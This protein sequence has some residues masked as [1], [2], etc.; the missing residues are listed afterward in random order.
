MRLDAEAARNLL[1]DAW[2]RWA[3]RCAELADDDWSAP[4]RCTGWD[5]AALIAHVCPEPTMFD[6]LAEAIT[7]PPAAVTDAAILLRRFNEPD[8]VANTG[9]DALAER[10]VTAAAALTPQTAAARFTETAERLRANHTR[11]DTVIAYPFV[12]ST[13][14]AVI[15]ETAL[16]EST[17]HLLDLAAA[18]GGVDPSPEALRATRDL[19]IA[20]P[21]PT[22]AVEALAGRAAPSTALPAIR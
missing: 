10:A 12:D 4:T 22:V 5:V 2:D 19:L 15:T 1:A 20:V 17:V 3:R 9:A 13:T 16:M 6:R 14:L 18:V 11:A 21:D 8:G 7:D